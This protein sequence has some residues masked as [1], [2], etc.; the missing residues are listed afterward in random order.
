MNTKKSKPKASEATVKPED[1][2]D[3]PSD[4][5]PATGG[6]IV[7]QKRRNHGFS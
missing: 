5:I 1:R 6:E 4:A 3:V 2:V 7:A